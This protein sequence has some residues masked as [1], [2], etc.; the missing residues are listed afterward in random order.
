LEIPVVYLTP[1]F[2]LGHFIGRLQTKADG[3]E[4]G[5][6]KQVGY[7]FIDHLHVERI[8]G[9]KITANAP[10]DYFSQKGNNVPGRVN[11]E[12]VV[13]KGKIM[14][15]RVFLPI[16]DLFDYRFGRARFETWRQF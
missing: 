9:V 5:V 4:T 13:I 15:R 14:Y 12:G 2:D 10:P 11:Q 8:G 1:S 16:D 3:F 6:K 7:L